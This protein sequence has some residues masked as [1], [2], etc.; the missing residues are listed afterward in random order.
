VRPWP[1]APCCGLD[2]AKIAVPDAIRR[3][4]S[5]GRRWREAFEAAK[6]A[7][8]PEALTTRPAPE[9]WSAVELRRPHPATCPLA[10]T[11]GS[12]KCSCTTG[13]ILGR[14][15]EPD[16]SRKDTTASTPTPCSRSFAAASQCGRPT[17]IA[18]NQRAEWT[19]PLPVSMAT[20]H[21]VVGR[22]A[23]AHE[24]S[25]HLRDVQRGRRC[26]HR[27]RS[28]TPQRLTAQPAHPSA[29]SASSPSIEDCRRTRRGVS[30][31]VPPA[32]W[33]CPFFA[34]STCPFYTQEIPP[35]P[36]HRRS[37]IHRARCL[38]RA[39]GDDVPTLALRRERR[40]RR[41][42]R[43]LVRAVIG[44]ASPVWPHRR[45]V[46]R[47]PTRL[48]IAHADPDVADSCGAPARDRLRAR[49]PPSSPSSRRNGGVLVRPWAHRTD[50]HQRRRPRFGSCACSRH[51]AIRRRGRDR[52]S[53]RPRECTSRRSP[54]TR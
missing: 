47:S 43:G 3:M 21:R 7:A 18:D 44:N 46:A 25:H 54:S 16:G 45:R 40:G 37:P 14:H 23:R 6:K 4:R 33:S 38:T 19:R 50:C 29:S 27:P 52:G 41:P 8:R 20:A 11:T 30:A 42:Y 26:A 24:G 48:R 51:D 31:R 13:R 49:R 35:S 1:P 9:T 22:A 39:R 34:P 10:S 36:G 17:G 5:F 15:S 2:E 28:V 12:A 32:S 53:P